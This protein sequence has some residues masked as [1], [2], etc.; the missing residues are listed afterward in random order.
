[1][2]WMELGDRIDGKDMGR[3]LYGNGVR[4]TNTIQESKRAP[5]WCLDLKGSGFC[6]LGLH[7]LLHGSHGFDSG[8]ERNVLA[9]MF[10]EEG[11]AGHWRMFCKCGCQ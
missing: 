3:L 4:R 10:E 6:I 9:E 2:E 8:E 11:L 1:M 7:G 5:I